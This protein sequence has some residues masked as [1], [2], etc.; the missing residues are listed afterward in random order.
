MKST[1]PAIPPYTPYLLYRFFGWI[2]RLPIPG[3]VL[4]ISVF[5]VGSLAMS[6]EAWRLGLVPVGEF[7]IDLLSISLFVVLAPALWTILNMNAVVAIEGFL[8]NRSA[9]K[10][11]RR[12]LLGEFLSVP[13][14]ATVLVVGIGMFRGYTTLKTVQSYLPILGQVLP[15]YSLFIAMATT[16]L[17]LL[18]LFRSIHQG[19]LIRRF[20]D[21][22]H[23]N[24]Y[25]PSPIYAL[26][27]YA[28]Q[29]ILGV[30]SAFLVV[31]LAN[32]RANRNHFGSLFCVVLHRCCWFAGLSFFCPAH[33]NQ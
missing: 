5:V 3:W 32:S 31:T 16:T 15:W 1:K 25:N 27:R 9:Q 19:M 28:S 13:N 26:S 12:A 14:I 10:Q 8:G 30:L 21:G 11:N 22:V 6:L 24:V 20:L 17:F 33:W 4:G 18:I 7:N 23:V 2:D 29:S